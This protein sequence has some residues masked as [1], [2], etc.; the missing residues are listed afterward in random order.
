MSNLSIEGII[1]I[2]KDCNEENK[3]DDKNGEASAFS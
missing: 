2:I 1:L 3:P